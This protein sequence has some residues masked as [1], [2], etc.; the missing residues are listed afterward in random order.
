MANGNTSPNNDHAP[1]ILC[2]IDGE[3][4]CPY[5]Y[6]LNP[7]RDVEGMPFLEEDDP[8]TCPDYG[9]ACPEFMDEF[10]LT[11][12]DL[13]I[14]AILHCGCLREYSIERG[15]ISGEDPR[16]QR[17]MKRYHEYLEKYPEEKFPQYY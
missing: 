13:N 16:V 6:S 12:D 8:R 3:G 17:L 14:R 1:V 10:G 7:D 2:E 15:E 9:H 5:D 4:G 11:V